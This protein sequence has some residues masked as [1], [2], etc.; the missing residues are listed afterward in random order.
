MVHNLA[1]FWGKAYYDRRSL[2]IP[3]EQRPIH[4]RDTLVRIL[5][6][7]F[8][9]RNPHSLDRLPNIPSEKH[10]QDFRATVLPS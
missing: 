8:L 3:P 5:R 7:Q 4:T 10:P 9:D 2:L 1:I 6:H